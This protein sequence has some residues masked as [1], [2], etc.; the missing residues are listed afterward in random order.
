MGR[1][2]AGILT[3][4]AGVMVGAWLI[5]AP[6]ALAYQPENAAWV[7]ATKVDVFT[8][9]G[10]IALGCVTAAGFAAGLV[11]TLRAEGSLPPRVRRAA[12]QQRAEV[13]DESIDLQGLVARLATVLE[14]RELSER[15]AGVRSDAR[16]RRAS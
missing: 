11:A 2:Y 4:I 9:L 5:A 7:D 10:L 15:D 1:F 6:F 12:T 3:G 16:E 13:M 14:E 8:G